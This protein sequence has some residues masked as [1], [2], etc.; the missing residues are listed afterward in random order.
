[1][2]RLELRYR[3]LLAWYPD[4]HRAQHEDEMVGVLLQAA[5]P[6][7]D[8]PNIQDTFDLLRGGLWLHLRRAFGR[9]SGESWRSA[10]A[11]AGAIGSCLMLA[12]FTFGAVGLALNF[13]HLTWDAAAS[14][15]L[16][17]LVVVLARSNL[18]APAAGTA[19]GLVVVDV[20]GARYTVNGVSPVE[21]VAGSPLFHLALVTALGLTLTAR[22]RAGQAWL[23]H[24][25]PFKLAT[26]F[27]VAL[28]IDAMWAGSF[29]G[30]VPLPVEVALLPLLVVTSVAMGYAFR[31]P[32]GR[33][34]ATLLAVPYLVYAEG[35]VEMS[36]LA[37]GW[38][39]FLIMLLPCTLVL[40][41]FLRQAVREGTRPRVPA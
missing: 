9:G 37:R 24:R 6:G 30:A 27:A 12:H 32:L 17:T 11:A 23:W 29:A 38:L 25:R 35:V 31:T 13:G 36:L 15:G 26:V 28:A 39:S 2:E 40:G 8:K 33:R 41:M 10:A 1:M 21:L 14:F 18:R 3:K 34:V 16:A 22:P 19:W 4:D 7:Q 20:L 5:G